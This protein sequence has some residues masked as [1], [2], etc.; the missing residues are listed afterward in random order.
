MKLPYYFFFFCGLWSHAL[1]SP[2]LLPP[3]LDDMNWNALE[4]DR[5]AEELTW[6]RVSPIDVAHLPTLVYP[7]DVNVAKNDLL[8]F[9]ADARPGWLTG[10]F[11]GYFE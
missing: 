6:E 3:P 11:G 8:S 7:P 1:N 2:P 9:C 4:W 10:V 5:A